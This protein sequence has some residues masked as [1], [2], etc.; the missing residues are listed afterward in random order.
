MV[1]LVHWI[2]RLLT[3]NPRIA[4]FVAL[5]F[6]IHPVN[7]D[8]V[9]WVSARTNLLATFFSLVALG[10]YGV[11]GERGFRLRYLALAFASFVL[12]VLAKSSAVV[13]PVALLLWDYLQGRRWDR[14]LVLEKLPFL[15]VALFI[16]VL[17]IQ[18]RADDV[19]PPVRYA[20]WDRLLL[21]LYALAHYCVR[22]VA[23]LGLSMNYA[24][25]VKSGAWLPL[26]Y[27]LAPFLLAAI[28]WSLS[29]LVPRRVVVFGLSFFVLNVALSQSV[30]LIDGFMANRYAYLAY[31]GLFLVLAHVHERGWSVPRFR[32]AWATAL[33]L[34]VAGFALLTWRR[35]LVWR[36][37]LALYDD[38]IEKGQGSP[39]V[40][41]ARGQV[42]LHAHDLAGAKR[43]LDRALKLDPSYTPGLCYRG[44]VSYR[45]Q[46]HPAALA[47]L[48]RA[49]AI[50]PRLSGAYRDRGKVKLA[51]GDEE[52]A[53]ADFDR[54]IVRDPRSEALLWRGA[55]RSDRG[56]AGGALADL[57]AWLAVAP[58]D[59]EAYFRRGLVELVLG[60]RAEAC[61]DVVRSRRLG[62]RPPE[63]VVAP[64]CP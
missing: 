49:L 50:D 16:G 39:W 31:L 21:F 20:P 5:A 1:L 51:L 29:R 26:Q 9:S 30:L 63:G 32:T 27:Y 45:L 41:G 15:A 23:P 24:H 64:D 18:L 60:D 43:D 3:R 12:A 17:A 28:A 54:A 7:V 61:E 59:G 8:T 35:T 58:D 33:V 38:V 25:P 14:R 10:C 4:L 34:L 11:H 37:S 36:D 40:Y 55:M 22:L 2:V 47:D 57:D 44:V 6:A 13:L 53:L 52:G 62:F 42:K 48:D 46:D 19:A 56:D